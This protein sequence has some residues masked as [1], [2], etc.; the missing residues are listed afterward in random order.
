MTL[1][2]TTDG[3][4]EDALPIDRKKLDL[5]AGFLCGQADYH[6]AAE[7]HSTRRTTDREFDR[8]R[9]R[10]GGYCDLCRDFAGR[11]LAACA[12]VFNGQS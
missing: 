11:I 4:V 5:L 7:A 6:D 1:V 10:N 2:L 3:R 9:E 12:E 8:Q